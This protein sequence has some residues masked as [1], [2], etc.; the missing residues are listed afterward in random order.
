MSRKSKKGTTFYVNDVQICIL[1]NYCS[2]LFNGFPLFMHL[3]RYSPMVGGPGCY[4]CIYCSCCVHSISAATT[5]V[6]RHFGLFFQAEDC[7]EILADTGFVFLGLFWKCAWSLQPCL[8]SPCSIHRKQNG[9]TISDKTQAV[10]HY[11]PL[12]RSENSTNCKACVHR[13]PSLSTR[14][15]V[16]VR[17]NTHRSTLRCTCGFSIIRPVTAT[18]KTTEKGV[19]A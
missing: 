7:L 11:H 9:Q 6:K 18:G 5:S 4:K 8:N 3:T 19:K 2:K 16:F 1:R 17:C 15:F 14:L 12:L 10:N 13:A